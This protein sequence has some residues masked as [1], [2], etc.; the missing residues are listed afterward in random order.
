MSLWSTHN[1]KK[2]ENDNNEYVKLRI[3]PFLCGVMSECCVYQ[4]SIRFT[5]QAQVTR[6]MGRGRSW[7]S[8][9]KYE[10]KNVKQFTDINLLITI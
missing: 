8:V 6:R 1:R 5:F 10:W 2:R 4:V 9:G 7:A 3:H